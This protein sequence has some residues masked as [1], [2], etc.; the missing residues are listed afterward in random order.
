MAHFHSL[1]APT[2]LS[3]YVHWRGLVCATYWCTADTHFCLHLDTCHTRHIDIVPWYLQQTAAHPHS[4]V[5]L[6]FAN[7]RQP[8][9]PPK[10]V[11]WRQCPQCTLHQLDV[12]VAAATTWHIRDQMRQHQQ[13]QPDHNHHQQFPSSQANE[14]LLVEWR[15]FME[16][17]CANTLRKTF[18]T[19]LS[20]ILSCPCMYIL[21]YYI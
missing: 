1:L 7:R 13:H 3:W 19:V 20:S 21:Y 17:E 6:S 16:C 2:L 18:K 5:S 12:G 9:A 14:T 8:N 10:C 15:L 11:A 4:I